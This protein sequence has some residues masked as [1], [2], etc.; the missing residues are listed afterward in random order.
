M[1]ADDMVSVMLGGSHPGRDELD[2][3]RREVV[4]ADETLAY[5]RADLDGAPDRR[6][7]TAVVLARLGVS[8][9]DELA[10][11]VIR[12]SDWTTIPGRGFI[13][14]EGA[15]WHLQEAA[16]VGRPT[17]ATQ[18]AI[19][20]LDRSD[21]G[22]SVWTDVIDEALHLLREQPTPDAAEAVRRIASEHWQDY[23]RAEAAEVLKD[24]D[25]A[26]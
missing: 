23:R 26:Q 10:L 25:V 1:T 16:R 6:L 15:M 3:L 12:E 11:L 9:A 13:V 8:D 2:E 22:A 24:I 20:A 19:E 7:A 21:P 5:L 18:Y 17:G 4:P 14:W